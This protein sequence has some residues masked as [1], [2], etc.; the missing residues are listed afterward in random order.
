M[1]Q[2]CLEAFFRTVISVG[3]QGNFHLEPKTVDHWR[4]LVDAC[5][6][7]WK[8]AAKYKRD[9]FLAYHY[10]TQLPVPPFE[11]FNDCPGRLFNGP[12]HG[13]F[14]SLVRW[15]NEGKHTVEKF[16]SLQQRRHSALLTLTSVKLICPRPN[17]KMLSDD[18]RKT[19]DQL[20]T[21]KK[22]QE[23][24]PLCMSNV[25]FCE[26]SD[27]SIPL[28][29]QA[30][31]AKITW[32]LRGPCRDMEIFSWESE[33]LDNDPE[34]VWCV[35]MDSIRKELVRK[36]IRSVLEEV[37]SLRDW[38]DGECLNDVFF[39]PT[40]ANYEFSIAKGGGVMGF[41]QDPELLLSEYKENGGLLPVMLMKE[42]DE[43]LGF[44]LFRFDSDDLARQSFVWSEC[45]SRIRNVDSVQCLKPV[46]LAE[47]LK[48]RV[49]TKGSWKVFMALRNLQQF[50]AKQLKNHPSFVLTGTPVTV[51]I[52]RLLGPLLDGEGF[53][54][55]DYASATN[56][57]K[58]WISQLYVEELCEYLGLSE[59]LSNLLLDGM[60]NNLIEDH[61]G[62]LLPQRSG[63]PM[64]FN[65]S[66]IGL[67]VCNAALAKIVR[68]AD[69]G[70]SHLA[71][72]RS[73]RM[74]RILIN[75]D[76]ILMPLTIRGYGYWEKIAA[77]IGLVPSVGKTYFTRE[78]AQ[79]NSRNFLYHNGEYY[80]VYGLNMGLLEGAAKKGRHV[81]DMTLP[82]ALSQ[83]SSNYRML[84]SDAPN[85]EE[86]KRIHGLFTRRH[87][88]RLTESLV[89]WYV[90]CWAGG[91]GLTGLFLPSEYERRCMHEIKLGIRR[92]KP[93]S[94]PVQEDPS[95]IAPNKEWSVHQ[96][97]ADRL[98]ASESTFDSDHPGVKEYERAVGRMS[99]DVLFDFD[100]T[101][102][103]VF[104]ETSIDDR[105]WRNLKHNRC[106]WRSVRRMKQ[107][108]SPLPL[109]MC[110]ERTVYDCFPAII[111][112][113]Y[114][115]DVLDYAS[116]S[117]VCDE[118]CPDGYIEICPKC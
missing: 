104:K 45:L 41:C 34:G 32:P 107:L 21:E 81:D 111:E 110:V 10:R 4:R 59:Q 46:A 109:K 77:W 65:N 5:K 75:G 105:A 82:C 54:N 30:A 1:I 66:F 35:P 50:L 39:P 2:E 15:R 37:V 55:G 23:E 43:V 26:S 68:M 48:V 20:T 18:I 64:G 47:P 114:S 58:S 83:L 74:A 9:A 3:L 14:N 98:P 22:D 36:T 8:S 60:V 63:Q 52:I 13:A 11:G 72:Y 80:N 27:H 57:I 97:A 106:I 117:F 93:K 12:L 31:Q 91:L 78:F 38:K 70:C 79:I 73:L 69:D 116:R 25:A 76:D 33:H 44:T 71:P 6:G 61:E 102:E 7:D 51:E 115:D 94:L 99:L 40:R 85:L 16:L 24:V 90:P 95:G 89:P 67:C 29:D 113:P 96:F 100:V 17:Q 87:F 42:S 53:L 19:V 28:H 92:Y 84:M 118:L 88:G 108:P 101:L 112:M 103:Q 62:R 56:N 49:I 86:K